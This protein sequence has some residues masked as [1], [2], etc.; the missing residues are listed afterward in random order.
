MRRLINPPDIPFANDNLSDHTRAWFAAARSF[1]VRQRELA[2]AG[3]AVIGASPKRPRRPGRP[4]GAIKARHSSAPMLPLARG[5]R[6]DRLA[7]IETCLAALELR[8]AR[9]ARQLTM[10]L[11]LVGLHVAVSLAGVGLVL[12]QLPALSA[13]LP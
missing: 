6:L 12:N 3:I 8:L 5:A 4:A 1:E 7:T 11:W 2:E 13:R 10:L 9:L